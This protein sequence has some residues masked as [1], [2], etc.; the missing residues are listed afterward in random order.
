[1]RVL[2]IIGIILL[3]L[4]IITTTLFTIY[5]LFANKLRSQDSFLVLKTSLWIFGTDL[6][7]FLKHKKEQ[8]TCSFIF[9]YYFWCLA[10]RSVIFYIFWSAWLGIPSFFLDL[11]PGLAFFISL[12]FA[13][14]LGVTIKPL[15]NRKQHCFFANKKW[16][17]A[18]WFL[19]SFWVNLSPQ[20]NFFQGLWLHQ[21]NFDNQG[22]VQTKAYPD[23]NHQSLHNFHWNF[24]PNHLK[25]FQIQK[26]RL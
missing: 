17:L 16:T 7:M 4:F 11:T 23:W 5:F 9:F 18:L 26:L 14:W 24:F 1:M 15:S 22:E 3:V 2:K 21:W 8:E 12:C 19:F 25:L 20:I 6:S 13:A 10:W